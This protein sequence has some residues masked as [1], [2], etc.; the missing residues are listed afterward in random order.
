MRCVPPFGATVWAQG[1][2]GRY[3]G[4]PLHTQWQ[5][6]GLPLPCQPDTQR[7]SSPR[8][9]HDLL[10][11]LCRRRAPSFLLVVRMSRFVCGLAVLHETL[12]GVPERGD[13]GHEGLKC[14]A[15]H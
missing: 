1:R 10:A 9:E 7:P 11:R 15:I 14:P 2:G 13:V 8:S 4:P 3:T 12:K 5:G 6:F